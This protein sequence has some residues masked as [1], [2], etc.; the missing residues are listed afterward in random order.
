MASNDSGVV[1]GH[2]REAA[3]LMDDEDD[4]EDYNPS[5]TPSPP[6]RRVTRSS[7]LGN[8]NNV[9]VRNIAKFWED[10]SKAEGGGGGIALDGAAERS[11]TGDGSEEGKLNKKWFSMP[12]LDEKKKRAMEREEEEA[13]LR[14]EEEE[15]ARREEEEEEEAERAASESANP[16]LV[17]WD[18][19][20]D[21]RDVCGTVPIRERMRMFKTMEAKASKEQAK[22]QKMSKWFSMPSLDEPWNRNGYKGKR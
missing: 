17:R 1:D 18:D 7:T 3:D 6:L 11:S 14:A 22:K 13:R 16:D 19:N 20:E 15:R 9:S 10:V 8:P 12:D 4:D 5:L 21:D 2:H